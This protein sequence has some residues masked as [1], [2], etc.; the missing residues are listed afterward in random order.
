MVGVWE[1]DGVRYA[2]F[3]GSAGGL[4]ATELGSGKAVGAGLPMSGSKVG[5]LPEGFD[6]EAPIAGS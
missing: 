1:L 3:P 6:P 5:P 4:E 2:V